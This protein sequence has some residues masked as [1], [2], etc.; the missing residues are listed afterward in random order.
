MEGRLAELAKCTSSLTL[1]R[2]VLV[3]SFISFL[4]KSDKKSKAQIHHN[5][6]L[7]PSQQQR[8]DGICAAARLYSAVEQRVST[9]HIQLYA[10]STTNASNGFRVNT[11]GQAPVP[12]PLLCSEAPRPRLATSQTPVRSDTK[13]FIRRIAHVRRTAL[14]PGTVPVI[15]LQARVFKGCGN[16]DSTAVLRVNGY[17]RLLHYRGN[18]RDGHLL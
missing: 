11:A 13:P 6:P 16:G 10:E 9:D 17:W 3:I 2:A 4:S 7:S 5:T 12:R 1:G 15:I 14:V 8:C 18:R